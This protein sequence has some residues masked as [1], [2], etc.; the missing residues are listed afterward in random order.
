MSPWTRPD[1]KRPRHPFGALLA[2]LLLVAALPAQALPDGWQ[3]RFSAGV[4][5][6]WSKPAS[7]DALLGLPR[8]VT[9]QASARL[10]WQKS[11]GSLTF[12]VHSVLNAEDGDAVAWRPILALFYPPPLPTT[13][14]NLTTTLQS[15][16]TTLVTNRIDRLSVTWSSPR[17]VLRLGRQAITWGGG[18]VFRPLDIVAP[19]PP[20]ATETAY[21]PGA[22]MLYAQV[23]F[24][25]GADIQAVAVPRP[26]TAGGPP[27]HYASTVAVRW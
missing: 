17:L 25:S 9:R 12:R 26:L 5:G 13:L 11:E 15:G 1:R 16:P 3:L 19:F 23:L 18:L 10:M 14:L 27:A 4:W 7:L 20:T 24:D 2:A 22:D 6:E 8:K 21:K